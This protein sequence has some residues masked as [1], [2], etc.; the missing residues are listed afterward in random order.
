MKKLNFKI[1]IFFLIFFIYSCDYPTVMYN[2]LVYENDF[3]NNSSLKEID[4]AAISFFND[5]YVLGDFNNDGFTLHLE[6]VIDHDYVFISFDLYIHGNWDGNSNGFKENDQADFW[7]IELNPD[8]QNISEDYHIF[9][10]TFS[11]S[12]CWPNYCLKQSYPD[13]YPEINNPKTGFFEENL[14]RKCDGFF[15]GS[16]TQ[17]KIEKTFQ[18]TGRSIIMRIHDMLYQPNAIDDF[19]NSQQKCDESWSVDNLKIRVVKYK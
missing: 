19:G 14:P 10:T 13:S 17:Y 7:I 9:R 8:M 12:P 15:G 3:E 6:D 5:S 18:S 1:L 2:E 16:T 4:G 11:S